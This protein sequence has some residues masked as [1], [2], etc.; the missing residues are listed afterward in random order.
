MARCSAAAARPFRQRQRQGR[1][2]GETLT[3]VACGQPLPG[4]EIRVVDEGGRELGERREGNIEFRGPSST[5]GYYR[6]GEATSELFHGEWL[7][8]GD[9]GYMWQGEIYI[10]GREK[11]T[12]VRAGR[13]I[14]AAQLEAAVSEV[15]GVRKGCVAIFGVANPKSGTEDLVVLAETRIED[16]G[17][18]QELEEAVNRAVVEALGEPADDVVLAPPHTVLKTSSGKIRR[19]A[20]RAVYQQG[21]HRTAP[22]PV[23]LQFTR[24]AAASIG[25]QAAAVMGGLRAWGYAAYWWLMAGVLGIGTWAVVSVVPGRRFGQAVVRAAGRTF[26]AAVG[27]PVRVHGLERWRGKEPR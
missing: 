18:R 7:R 23:W 22:P 12:I 24:L 6:N 25:P 5:Q 4:H 27:A 17:E 10:S 14:Y 19:A 11:D 9:R 13:N 21:G 15:P 16:T 2:A 3:F 8:T 1:G 26:L 20:T